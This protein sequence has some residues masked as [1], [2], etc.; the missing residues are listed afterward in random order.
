MM[1]NLNIRDSVKVE[2]S[3]SK[4]AVDKGKTKMMFRKDR[5]EKSL[6]SPKISKVGRDKKRLALRE[7]ND[8]SLSRSN[9]DTMPQKTLRDQS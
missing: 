2:G 3:S 1:R 5:P 8:S 6:F 4:K 7:I 9:L